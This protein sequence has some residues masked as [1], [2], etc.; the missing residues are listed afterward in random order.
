MAVLLCCSCALARDAKPKSKWIRL[1]SAHFA[2]LTDA[3]EK[4]GKEVILRLEQMRAAFGEL[5]MRP[6]LTMP[7]PIDVIAFETREEYAQVSP[8][9]GGQPISSSGFFLPGDDRS[10]IVLDSSDQESWRAVSRQ[11]ALL[12]SNY[13]YPPT[14]PWFDEGVAQ[15]FSSLRL[16]DSQE[17]IGGDPASLVDLLNAQPWL[18]V[19]ELFGV[20]QNS[21]HD[22]V[23]IRSPLFQAES[24][25]VMHYL[26]SQQKLPETGTYFGLVENQKVP[27][28]Q[29]IQRAYGVSAAQFEPSV[30]G[31]FHSIAPALQ[32]QGAVQTPAA[33]SVDVGPVHQLA[34]VVPDD[35]GTSYV[36]VPLA[37]AQA[38][39]AEMAARLPDRRE[40]AV[41]DLDALIDQPENE[42]SIAHRAL[43]WVDLQN[44]EYPDA[45]EE[46][47]KGFDLNHNDPWVNYY[48]ALVK[49][50]AA[51]SKG[52]D[53]EGLSNMIQSLRAVI[54][55]DPDFAEAYNMLAMAQLEGG[56]VHAAADSM[57]SA[58]L[59]NPRSQTY[60]LNMAHIDLEAKK[61][62]DATALLDRLKDGE[63]AQV[64]ATARQDLEDLPTLRKYGIPPERKG[65]AQASKLVES[66]AEAEDADASTGEHTR[67]V[68]V[69]AGPD[70]RKVQF[71]QG[72]LVSVDCSQPPAAILKIAAGAQIMRLRTGDYKSLL[73]IGADEFSCE[74][75]GVSVV[76]NYKASGKGNGDLVSLELR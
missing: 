32:A 8:R 64:A 69:D 53:V 60:L 29:A 36:A 4:N 65:S 48:L 62:D 14:Q 33:A 16:S 40:Q 45:L 25:I 66:T 58:I 39:V 3:G 41:K 19:T 42:T 34:P 20:R 71:V 1:S 23:T 26:L 10:Y 59:L 2:I 31:Y 9:S 5:L 6:K 67:A 24:W 49:Y 68:P 46:L 44:R 55:W 27:V 50:Q 74:W 35:I 52:G 73:L 43:A 15:Y 11:F 57:R 18:P 76:V 22:K 12:Y 61:W 21:A 38:L 7:E 70:R 56:G 17:K 63:D 37:E 72:K 51:Q 47:G 30:K 13:N 28:G 75:K 54:D